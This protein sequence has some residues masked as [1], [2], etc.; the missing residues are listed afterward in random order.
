[1][2]A[3]KIIRFRTIALLSIF[4]SLF[5][6]GSTYMCSEALAEADEAIHRHDTD[7]AK[8]PEPSPHQEKKK[9]IKYWVAPMDPNYVRDKP[10]KSPMG[11]DLIP[12][13]EDD[14]GTSEK[15]VIKIDPV[16]V[17]N[18]G[19]RTATVSRGSV[20]S[21]IRT[22]GNITYDEE[23]VEHIHT[24]ISGWVEEL[25]VNTTGEKVNKGQK[26]LSLYS[27]DLV[28]TQEEY[29]QALKYKEKVSASTFPD[30][31]RSADTLIEAARK[32]LMLM[33]ID[34]GQ[35]NAIAERGEVQKTLKLLSPVTGIVIK[36]NVLEGMK[37]DLGME[38]YTIADLSRVWVIASIYEYE[39]PFIKL[40]Q[41]AEMSLPYEPGAIYHG[42]ITFIYPYLSSKTR[43][44]QVR[45]EFENPGGKLKPDMYADVVISSEISGKILL[46]P[47]EAVI[48]TGSRNIVVTSL[49]GGKFLPKEITAGSEGEGFI[50]VLSGLDEGDT[51][52]TSGQFLIDSESNLREAMNKMLEAQQQAPA[53]KSNQPAVRKPVHTGMQEMK[54]GKGA[55][56]DKGERSL[57]MKLLDSYL[58]IHDALVAESPSDAAEETNVMAG[59]LK[60]IKSSGAEGVLN[61]DI[62]L[63]EESL[64]GLSSGELEKARHSFKSLSKAVITFVKGPAREDAISSGIKIYYCPMEKERWL[65]KGRELKNPYLG[66]DMLICG[67]EEK[68]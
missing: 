37:L 14:E 30:V 64:K 44:V 2:T 13:Y 40:G 27:P 8:N 42:R 22:I 1:M 43:T 17:Q 57:I 38:L 48:R 34:I 32:R 7:S 35:I 62:A 61:E 6:F 41:E 68:Y 12:V 20:G 4:F 24:K 33:D 47:S 54:P 51:V 21:T 9:K 36:K 60:E 52:V 66:K 5:V 16:T 31:V 23:K 67:S 58:K 55:A 39:L 46:V 11:M 3:K 15:G 50:Q 65:Q 59:G 26:L 29:L 10:G 49:G 56:A 28:A 19:V 63:I 53:D 25:F 45:M 18:I